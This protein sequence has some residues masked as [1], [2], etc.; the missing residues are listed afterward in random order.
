MLVN[1]SDKKFHHNY[2]NNLLYTK[3]IKNILKNERVRRDIYYYTESFKKENRN[4]NNIETCSIM[5]EDVGIV[6]TNNYNFA[7][8]F[9]YCL[10]L[11]PI[12]AENIN[13]VN[14]TE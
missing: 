10:L 5:K 12:P 8:N 7:V 6:I 13:T 2:A 1:H 11:D 3:I 4:K 9:E 14:E